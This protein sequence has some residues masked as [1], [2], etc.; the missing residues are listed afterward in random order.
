[1]RWPS[2]ASRYAPLCRGIPWIEGGCNC[3]PG[4]RP[5][6][7]PTAAVSAGQGFG[8]D[9]AELA[10]LVDHDFPDERFG[11]IGV[12]P[13]VKKGFADVFGIRQHGNHDELERR[14]E[15]VGLFQPAQLLDHLGT[16]HVRHEDV[17][18][19]GGKGAFLVEGGREGRQ[20]LHPVAGREA[21]GI[22]GKHRPQE[23]DHAFVVIHDE[24][25]HGL[26]PGAAVTHNGT[27]RPSLGNLVRSGGGFNGFVDELDRKGGVIAAQKSGHAG[28]RPDIPLHGGE[29]EAFGQ[30]GGLGQLVGGGPAFH[31]VP[32]AAER[33]MVAV[34]DRLLELGQVAVLDL[35]ELRK[36][37]LQKTADTGYG[38]G[39]SGTDGH[40]RLPG[41]ALDGSGPG[42]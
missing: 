27:S 1:V 19:H 11:Q 31:A 16:V 24:K 3:R 22:G 42:I 34:G 9:E 5:G 17:H 26:P 33:R 20:G 25:T 37:R 32:E 39:G 30:D 41:T 6:A 10:E 15:A 8:V 40:A 4:Q 36:N 12:G 21:F 18:E 14:A 13:A 29:F 23:E 7:G 35:E 28:R 38:T 2:E